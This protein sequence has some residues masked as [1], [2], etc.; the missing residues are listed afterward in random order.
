MIT[1]TCNSCSTQ[2]SRKVEQ[3][4]E[5][6]VVLGELKSPGSYLSLHEK[7][8]KDLASAYQEQEK[9]GSSWCISWANQVKAQNFFN[10]HGFVATLNHLSELQQSQKDCV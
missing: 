3:L 8:C 2:A 9:P 10:E 6:K 4:L 1:I 7:L 5:S